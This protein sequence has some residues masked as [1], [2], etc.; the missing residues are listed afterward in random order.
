MEFNLDPHYA[1]TI[2]KHL[3]TDEG[4]EG[5]ALYQPI[6]PGEQILIK[7]VELVF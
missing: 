2:I 4:S 5:P 1:Y 3:G 7:A 6:D